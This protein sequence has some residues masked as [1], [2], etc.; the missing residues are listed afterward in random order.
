MNIQIDEELIFEQVSFNNCT[1]A[2]E[3]ISKELLQ[4]GY[5]KESYYKSL[6]EREKIFPTGIDFG[7][8]GIAIPHTDSEHVNSST[9][10]LITLKEPVKFNSMEDGEKQIDISMICGIVLKEK[11][12]QAIFLSNLMCLFSNKEL[13]NKLYSGSKKEK[14][15]ILSQLNK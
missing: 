2:L 14:I 7:E 1:E 4:R 13:A 3:F 15:E 11:E 9:L 8:I 10:V 5:V 6:I 12:K